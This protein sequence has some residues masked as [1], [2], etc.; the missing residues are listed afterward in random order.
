MASGFGPLG[1]SPGEHAQGRG[2]MII[3]E[4]DQP[5]GGL[6]RGLKIC[7]IRCLVQAHPESAPRELPL[8]HRCE[9]YGDNDGDHQQR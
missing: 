6:G 7:D 4:V 2:G 8:Q 5:G 9:C 1:S 3:P